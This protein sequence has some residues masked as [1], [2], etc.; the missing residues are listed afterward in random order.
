M[1]KRTVVLALLLLLTAPV[2]ADQTRAKTDV[3]KLMNAMLPFAEQMLEKHGEFLPYGAAM[4]PAGKVVSIGGYDGREHPPSQ[5]IIKL[6]KDSFRSAAKAKKYKAT[7]IF[8][9]VRTVPPGAVEKT[10]AVAIALDH[11]DNYSVVVYYPYKLK[12]GKV[13]FGQVFATAGANDIFG[14]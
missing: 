10:D 11:K 13:Q 7:G 6:L 8:F 3:E 5:D 12:S 1:I 14:K 9:D 2:G 4:T